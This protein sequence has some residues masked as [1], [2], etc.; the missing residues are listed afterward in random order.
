MAYNAL[1]GLENLS[2][3]ECMIRAVAS[4]LNK[5]PTLIVLETRS[6]QLE[7]NKYQKLDPLKEAENLQIILQAFGADKE[8]KVQFVQSLQELEALVEN[9]QNVFVGFAKGQDGQNAHIVHLEKRV[10]KGFSSKQQFTSHEA[11]EIQL[12]EQRKLVVFIAA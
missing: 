2:G 4:A 5:E 1:M 12:A 11:L 10:H 8:V 3:R 9:N 7:E 6:K